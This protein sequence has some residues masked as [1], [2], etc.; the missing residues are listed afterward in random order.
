MKKLMIV[1]GLSLF[2]NAV[3]FA[4]SQQ[5]QIIAVATSEKT[6]SSQINDKAARAPYYLIFDKSGKLLEIVSN[7]FC[8]DDRGAGPKV[9]DLLS[10]KNVSVVVSGDFGNKIKSA[11]DKKK[12]DFHETSGIVKNV[13]E[14]LIKSN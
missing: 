5:T 11:L 7:P 10:S 12:I 2:L 14:D 9:A 4:Q 1:V 13:V 8:D 6:E 3:A